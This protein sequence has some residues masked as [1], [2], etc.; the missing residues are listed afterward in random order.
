MQEIEIIDKKTKLLM[1]IHSFRFIPLK[2]L[3]EIV[4]DKKIYS[5][6]QSFYYAIAGLEKD[7]FIDSYTYGISHNWK[8]VFISTKGAKYLYESLGI[9]AIA[10]GKR[11][12]VKLSMLEH[13]VEIAKI[14]MQLTK[15][16]QIKKWLGDQ[17]VFCQYSYHNG[18][19]K[20]KKELDP[21]GYFEVM[22]EDKFIPFFLEFDT[23]TMDRKA[24]A[25]KFMRYFEYFVY[26]K[27]EEKYM[28]FPNIFFLTE[29]SEQSMRG[30][31]SPETSID[32][33]KFSL[34]RKAFK[35]SPNIIYKGIGLSETVERIKSDKIR[36]FLKLNFIFTYKNSLWVNDILKS[37]Q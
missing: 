24:L 26:G 20:V 34:D 28:Q 5:H 16:L 15:E 9:P 21:D 23:G 33:S 7:G 19:K 36:E 1:L 18:D 25:V 14:Y 12:K 10:P 29:R 31:I 35:N 17:Q 4:L 22:H 6:F 2:I 3:V 32:L 27:W 8:V 30:M 11:R 13:T 37:L